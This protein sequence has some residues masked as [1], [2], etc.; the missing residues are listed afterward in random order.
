M[1]RAVDIQIYGLDKL[2][3]DMRS[4]PAEAQDELRQAS[5]DI[6][7]GPMLESWQAAALQA[8]PW[9][10]RLA[11]SIRVKK[12]RIPSINIGTAGRSF[13][14][15]ASTSN[16]RFPTSEGNSGRGGQ[17]TYRGSKKLANRDSRGHPFPV[18]FGRGTGWLK[19]MGKYKPQAL[20]E[21]L[22]AVDRIKRK[23]ERG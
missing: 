10:G 20:R 16:V 11:D 2:M 12:D 14:G 4:L 19:Q 13:S 8:G 22:A 9:G 21:W 6:A 5:M 17:G 3:R 23:F 7:G 18:A 15:G 1:P